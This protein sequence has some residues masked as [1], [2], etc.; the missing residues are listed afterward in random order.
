MELKIAKIIG[1]P[2]QQSWS[3][4]HFFE[5]KDD[6]KQ[7][8]GTL[9]ASLS[10][11]LK[12]EG[13]DVALLGKELIFRLHE[14]YYASASASLA[15]LK[16][17]VEAVLEEFSPTLD[18]EIQTAVLI[19]R[20]ILVTVNSGSVYLSRQAELY[21]LVHSQ[22]LVKTLSGHL[23]PDDRF[24]L[25]SS[26]FFELVPQGTLK[27]SLGF[28]NLSQTVDVLAPIVHAHQPNSRVVAVIVQVGSWSTEPAMPVVPLNETERPAP[29]FTRRFNLSG[30]A[31]GWFS[32]FKPSGW[33]WPKLSLK[34]PSPNFGF[35]DQDRKTKA[36]RK[37]LLVAGLLLVLLAVSL[38]FGSKKRQADQLDRLR[39][40]IIQ[41]ALSA[42]DQSR[43]LA[44]QNPLQAKAQLLQAQDDLNLKKSQTTD[45]RILPEIDQAL[46]KIDNELSAVTGL[47]K[48]ENPDLFLDLSLIKTGWRGANL[49]LAGGQLVVTSADQ[50]EIILIDTEDKNYEKPTLKLDDQQPQEGVLISNGQRLVFLT[51]KNLSTYD[52]VKKKTIQDKKND[53]GQTV[54]LIG[55]ESNIYLLQPNKILKFNG[56]ES[57]LGNPSEY[58]K[59]QPDWQAKDMAVDGFVWVLTTDGQVYKYLS[60][61]QDNLVFLGLEET[62]NDLMLFTDKDQENLYLLDR[63]KT[64]LYQIDKSGEYRQ[65]Y[66]WPGISGAIDFVVAEDRN[67]AFFLTSDKIYTINL[68][69]D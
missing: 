49:S 47:Q 58:L 13:A 33:R 17:A 67:A 53:W 62:T 10:F 21:P 50:K 18:L 55:F 24:L 7:S 38:Y 20:K 4:I 35:Q 61:R 40:E 9:V 44:S 12:T 8:H 69:P 27:A 3:Q 25:A 64:K 66:F 54:R 6:K 16:Q 32:R 31:A 22:S 19:K 26:P 68:K 37:T 56:M 51:D 57:G 5:P 29:V 45:Q 2:D 36:R 11:S 15:H 59:D 34:R 43:E 52:L 41:P 14:S 65:S 48:I 63:Q 23:Q 42:I 1:P 60:G 28:T 39:Q 46:L 30:Q